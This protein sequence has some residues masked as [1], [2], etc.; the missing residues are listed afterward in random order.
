MTTR[1]EAKKLDPDV[2]FGVGFHTIYRDDDA[3]FSLLLNWFL[4]K[5][6][7]RSRARLIVYEDAIRATGIWTPEQAGDVADRLTIGR[8]GIFIDPMSIKHQWSLVT[9]WFK[10]KFS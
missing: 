10:K 3:L 5:I 6:K 2:N 4:Q 8:E 1:E 9:D 7:S